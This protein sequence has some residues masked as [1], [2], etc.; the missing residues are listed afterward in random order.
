M[1][2]WK[3][4]GRSQNEKGQI[5]AELLDHEYLFKSNTVSQQWLA[6]FGLKIKLPSK[7]KTQIFTYSFVKNG[8]IENLIFTDG[9]NLCDCA[10]VDESDEPEPF[11][12]S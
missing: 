9:L 10:A 1:K 12:Q 5:F 4:F 6:Q 7:R 3:T 11:L 2:S 8:I